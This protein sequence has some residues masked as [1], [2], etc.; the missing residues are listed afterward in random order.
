[1]GGSCSPLGF[2]GAPVASPSAEGGSVSSDDGA[3]VLGARVVGN[4]VVV[5]PLEGEKVVSAG[6]GDAVVAALD[7]AGVVILGTWVD[8]DG[9][10]APKKF[11]KNRS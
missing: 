2:D 3:P 11:T 9:E 8:G 1:M 6:V 10:D 7:G 5:V 4:P